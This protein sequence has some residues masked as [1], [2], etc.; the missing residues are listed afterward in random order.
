VRRKRRVDGLQETREIPAVS[1]T[2]EFDEQALASLPLGPGERERHMQIELA[3][4]YYAR[5]WLS[6]AQAARLAA[7][8]HYAFGVELGERGIPRQ[9]GLTEAQEDVAHAGRQ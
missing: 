8:D 9:Y 2:L 1:I 6:F 3:C 7:L 5:G 4:R